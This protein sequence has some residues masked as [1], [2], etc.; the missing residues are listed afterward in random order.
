MADS[1][2]RFDGLAE[3]YARGRPDYPA[4]AVEHIL[5]RSALQPGDRVV[6]IGSGTGIFSRILASRG[7]HVIGIEPNKEMRA[8]AE[9]TLVP[10]GESSPEYRHG[11]GEVTGLENEFAN[12]VTC[13]QAFHWLQSSN[14][15]SEFRRILKPGG[16]V[17]LLWNERNESDEF[18]A[19]CGEI[20]RR[21]PGAL[22]LEQHRQDTGKALLTHPQF[23][24]ACV[25]CFPHGQLLREDDL[26]D[27]VFSASY[28]PK[29][30][31]ERATRSREL[32]AVF[33]QFHEAGIVEL[34]Y[35]TSVF[36]AHR[37]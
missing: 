32:R 12:A 6:D 1:A 17:A 7:L 31:R 34:R 21:F 16:W 37:V 24:D 23:V 36:M 4:D 26:I 8:R 14:A 5:K 3:V 18:T 30:E 19:A 13:A 15:L 2:N 22:Q 25:A 28:A 10:S 33:D 35:T 29:E 27:R 9:A 20:I 11:T